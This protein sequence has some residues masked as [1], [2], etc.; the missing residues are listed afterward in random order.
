M[1]YC[2]SYG[3]AIRSNDNVVAYPRHKWQAGNDSHVSVWAAFE[4]NT[5]GF[6]LQKVTVV[7]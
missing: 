1:W 6:I 4:F 2:D 3:N 7:L 5:D